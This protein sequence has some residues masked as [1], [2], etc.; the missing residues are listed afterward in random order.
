MLILRCVRVKC[1]RRAV[2]E[3]VQLIVGQLRNA[4]DCGVMRHSRHLSFK[5]R[6]D[7]LL[8]FA[9]APSGA[10]PVRNAQKVRDDVKAHST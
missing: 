9:V 8:D 3:P 7:R 4:S 1:M 5:T 10:T 2:R 6:T